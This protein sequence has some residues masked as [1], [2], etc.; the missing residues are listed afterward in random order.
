MAFTSGQAIF[1]TGGDTTES[2]TA[3]N[4]RTALG[5][6]TLATVTPT[7]T[8]D[9][10]K[11]LRDDNSWQAASGGGVAYDLYAAI[12][13]QSGTSAPTATVLQNDLSGAVVWTRFDVGVYVGTLSSA[14]PANKVIVTYGYDFQGSATLVFGGR[15]GNNTIQLMTADTAG[16]SIDLDGDITLRVEVYP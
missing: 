1:A 16:A 4:A 11:F 14:F 2:K 12:I 9:G 13:S 7:G 3:A 8:P 10:T 15:T 5:L 6:G